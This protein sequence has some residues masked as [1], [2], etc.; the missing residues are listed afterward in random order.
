MRRQERAVYL[1]V[2]VALVPIVG[3]ACL[4][5]GL[6]LWAARVPLFAV[7]ALVAMVGNISAI[8]RLGAVAEAVRR[9]QPRRVPQS[10]E[11]TSLARDAHAATG[12]ALR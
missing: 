3:A 1:V 2:G 9:P 5:T 12:D 6:P 7:L 10:T 11:S 8:R 4:R